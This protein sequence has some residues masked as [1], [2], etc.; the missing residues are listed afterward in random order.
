LGW[1]GLDCEQVASVRCGAVFKLPLGAWHSVSR[2]G[3]VQPSDN[4]G[5][6][7]ALEHFTAP[8]HASQPRMALVD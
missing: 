7:S 4:A 2:Q 3:Y 8:R 5:V 1:M 6:E